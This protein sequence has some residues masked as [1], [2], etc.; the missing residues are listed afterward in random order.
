MKELRGIISD[1]VISLNGRCYGTLVSEGRDIVT[2]TVLN[3][4]VN[5]GQLLLETKNSVYI[6]EGEVKLFQTGEEDAE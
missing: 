5:E 6:I 4:D 3:V 2:S 1:A